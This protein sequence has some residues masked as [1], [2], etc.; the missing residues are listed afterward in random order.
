M[1]K[2]LFWRHLA[3]H[4]TTASS[5]YRKIGLDLSNTQTVIATCVITKVAQDL[6]C[7]CH[8]VFLMMQTR[9]Y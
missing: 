6:P 2:T 4:C 9:H 5:V 8:A 3:L 1:L 7:V